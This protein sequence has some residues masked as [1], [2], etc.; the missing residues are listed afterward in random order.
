[1]RC[2]AEWVARNEIVG[3]YKICWCP[4]QFVRDMER[5]LTAELME[6][7]G[8][9]STRGAKYLA[10]VI[11]TYPRVETE[12]MPLEIAEGLRESGNVELARIAT[13]PS[14]YSRTKQFLERAEK[15]LID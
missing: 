14:S 9:N 7:Y 5:H 11:R 13:N 3:L 12:A 8:K 4:E 2:G 15:I 1:M 10:P 6:A